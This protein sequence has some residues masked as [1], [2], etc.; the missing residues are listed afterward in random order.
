MY[1]NID[2]ISIFT[3][4]SSTTLDVL[5]S[6]VL[7]LTDESGFNFHRLYHR[8]PTERQWPLSGTHSIMMVKSA[9]PGEDGVCTPSP[10][11]SIY[12]HEQSCGVH[13][14]R[15][16]RY[17]PL[18]LSPLPLYV[19]CGLYVLLCWTQKPTEHSSSR[20]VQCNH[21]ELSLI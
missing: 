2:K 13:S 21:L 9:Q 11:R 6:R 12:H 4:P 8:V 10:F 18:F 19:I 17:I 1:Y 5:N 15:E 16:G 3:S 7:K 20:S 14:S